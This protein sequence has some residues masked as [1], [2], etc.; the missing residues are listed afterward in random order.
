M[1]KQMSSKAAEMKM[2]SVRYSKALEFGNLTENTRFSLVMCSEWEKTGNQSFFDLHAL[3]KSGVPSMLRTVVWSD[4]MK[5]SLIEIDEKKHMLRNYPQKYNKANSVFENFSE[6]SQKY[7][8][9][10]FRQ[11]DQD[12]SDFKFPAFY[13]EESLDQGTSSNI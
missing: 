13:F 7:D 1:I 8:S 2:N 11:I 12:I 4:L 3:I 10:A 9:V 6:I 5:T